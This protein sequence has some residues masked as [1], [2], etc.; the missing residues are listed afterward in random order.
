MLIYSQ[1]DHFSAPKRIS[2]AK[3]IVPVPV[4]IPFHA[5]EIYARCPSGYGVTKRYSIRSVARA[6]ALEGGAQID[7]VFDFRDSA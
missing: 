6:A 1:P 2:R 5:P 3:V 4:L 7:T